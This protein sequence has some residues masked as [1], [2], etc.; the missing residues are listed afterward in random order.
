[1]YTAMFIIEILTFLEI[2][3]P[4]VVHGIISLPVAMSYEWTIKT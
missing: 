2:Y 4:L 3:K 1:M